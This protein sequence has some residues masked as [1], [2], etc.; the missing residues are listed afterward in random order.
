MSHQLTP[1]QINQLW[2]QLETANAEIAALRVQVQAQQ[3][4][5]VQDSP[6]SGTLSPTRLGK[7]PCVNVPDPFYGDKDKSEVFLAQL[8]LSFQLQRSRFGD[9]RSKVLFAISYMK[10]TAFKWALPYLQT[11]HELISNYQQF[12]SAFKVTFGD[13]NRSRQAA[14][15]LLDLKQGRRP[16]VAYISDFQRF[17][18]ELGWEHSLPLIEMFDRGLNK[19][20]KQAL[21]NFDRPT[22][23]NDIYALV[24]RIDNRHIEFRQEYTSNIQPYMQATTP[25]ASDGVQDMVIGTMR[26][27]SPLTAEE[28]QR[29]LNKNLCLY[30]GEAGHAIALCPKR[31]GSCHGALKD[32]SLIGTSFVIGKP[33]LYLS[34][35][36]VVEGKSTTTLNALVDSGADLSL[37]D[38][39]LLHAL[40]ISYNSLD[41]PITFESIEGHPLSGGMIKHFVVLDF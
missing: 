2:T 5:W 24:A 38:E 18:I 31:L 10:G 27:R 11:D 19:E 39:N 20:I 34:I 36:L 1:E 40:N 21:C 14:R 4:V 6:L 29:R 23:L 12:E 8:S 35:E 25:V 32:Q 33:R 7:E 17:S 30:C 26:H 15:E 22:C 28:R 3:E 41:I 9:D 16:V 37:V 13:V